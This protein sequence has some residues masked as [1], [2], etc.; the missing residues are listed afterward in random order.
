MPFNSVDFFVFLATVF[1]AHWGV[2]RLF[3]SYGPLV[4][5]L[6]LIVASLASYAF[7]D[8]QFLSL[9]ILEIA[10]AYGL[11]LVLSARPKRLLLLT[12]ILFYVGVLGY[13]KYAGFFTE[14]LRNAL[15]MC[16]WTPDW[17]TLKIV[18]PIGI[19][20]FTFMCLGYVVD[21]YLKRVKAERNPIVFLAM[22]SFFPQIVAGPIG[23]IA[24]LGPQF[25]KTRAF[26]GDFA[27]SGLTLMVQGL[28]K[29]MVVAD[30]LGQYV[31]K[32]FAMPAYFDA[33]TCLVAAIF[34]TV[35]IYCDFSGYSDIARGCARL[36]G[37]DL[38]QNFERP[39][40][41]RT[42]GEFWHRWH[43]SLSTWF[44]DYVYIPLGGSRVGIGR[45]IAN[46]WI[47]FLLSGLWHG[48]A[49][50]FVVWG[51]LHALYLTGG[52]LKKR[53]LPRFHRFTEKQAC[54]STVLVFL[55]VSVA[56]IVFR[57][58]TFAVLCEFFRTIATGVWTAPH[59]R[60]EGLVFYLTP[61][62]L[63]GLLWLSSLLPFDCAYKTLRARLI[64]IM[65]GIT[66]IVFLG[67]PCGGEFIY[68]RF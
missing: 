68:Q 38:M 49:W 28:V 15:M 31:D 20:F 27:L 22:M 9:L 3:A 64:F 53:Y 54:L 8:L 36:F 39:Y 24:Y 47:V 34:F 6:V 2:S 52:I 56:W 1:A 44:R 35:Q 65:G 30:T 61:Y 19:S 40:L 50:T 17:A 11:G 42:F 66:L 16:G 29:K 21:V 51:A 4:Q 45:L 60:L 32:V 7:W 12:A 13:F 48:A 37:I 63:I 25:S 33:S 23:R 14:S 62:A 26:D 43:I 10:I 57:A 41:A 67:L 55:G 59:G 58:P 5:N 46:T 18:T